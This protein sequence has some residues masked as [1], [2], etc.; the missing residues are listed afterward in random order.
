MDEKRK[1]NNNDKVKKVTFHPKD[2]IL[3]NKTDVGKKVLN[4]EKKQQ[5][6]ERDRERET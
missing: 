3:K 4:G 1:I 6:D 5:K 2:Y